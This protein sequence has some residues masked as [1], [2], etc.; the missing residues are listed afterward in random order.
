MSLSKP[1]LVLLES[2]M[3][4]VD[5]WEALIETCKGTLGAGE[6]S[7]PITDLLA[8]A[9]AA[10]LWRFRRASQDSSEI[11]AEV[12]AV[13]SLSESE[14]RRNAYVSVNERVNTRKVNIEAIYQTMDLHDHLH[15]R[16]GK[17]I[18]RKSPRKAQVELVVVGS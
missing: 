12:E 5:E 11:M 2:E 6:D 16:I 14:A 15:G 9:M 3:D 13:R 7:D 17:G 8:E 4:R 1:E 18:R 10:D